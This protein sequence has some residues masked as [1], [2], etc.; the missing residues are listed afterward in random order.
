[1]YIVDTPGIQS[2]R[3]TNDH[4]HIQQQVWQRVNR[5]NF[6]KE[7]DPQ[8][9]EMKPPIHWIFKNDV[10][11]RDTAGISIRK[12]NKSQR[13]GLLSY[14]LHPCTA[15]S[16]TTSKSRN[17]G[18]RTVEFT[19]KG[20]AAAVLAVIKRGPTGIFLP[21]SSCLLLFPS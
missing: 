1:M 18:R 9:K 7:V 11:A 16:Y 17:R 13:S 15:K 19:T 20:A 8:P 21:S 4:K 12:S 6:S 10:A 5:A 14:K 2:P 3:K